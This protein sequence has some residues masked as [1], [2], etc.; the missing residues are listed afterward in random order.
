IEEG[1]REDPTKSEFGF[2]A[3][4]RKGGYRYKDDS[5]QVLHQGV[6]RHGLAAAGFPM[7]PVDEEMASYYQRNTPN[8]VLLIMG[9][10]VSVVE[11]NTNKDESGLLDPHGIILSLPWMYQFNIGGDGNEGIAPLN[12]LA[13]GGEMERIWRVSRIDGSTGNK[14]RIDLVDKLPFFAGDGS[15][16]ALQV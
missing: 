14:V 10:G 4:Y 2:L 7:E 6:V 16:P 11:I 1:N 5:K 9:A 13:Q 3:R 15:E 8:P 12:T